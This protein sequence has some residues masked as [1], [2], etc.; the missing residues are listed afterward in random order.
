MDKKI[1][2]R[3]IIAIIF[4]AASVIMTSEMFVN[5]I[6]NGS[7]SVINK[8]LGAALLGFILGGM[9]VGFTHIPEIHKKIKKTLTIPFA[10]WMAYLVLIFAIPYFGG[11]IFMLND[12]V[13]FLK[14]RKAVQ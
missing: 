11:W 5:N 10:G 9:I 3:G 8:L 1:K 4:S 14:A 2:I 13:K 7:G 12:L 6:K